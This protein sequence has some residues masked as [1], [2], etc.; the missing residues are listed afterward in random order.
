MPKARVLTP[1]V[2][3]KEVPNVVALTCVVVTTFDATREVSTE[4]APTALVESAL[5]KML[6]PL[7]QAVLI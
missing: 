4:T 6:L 5:A 2:A 7:T 1:L 3:T